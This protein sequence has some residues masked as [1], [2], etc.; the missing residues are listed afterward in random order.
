MD[1]IWVVVANQAGACIYSASRLGEVRSLID[2]FE[3][4]A[5][6]AHIQELVS[7]APGR[8]HDRQGEARH[9]METDVGMQEESIRRFARKIV[10]YLEKAAEQRKYSH[11]VIIAAPAFLGIVRKTVQPHLADRI[12]LEIPKDIVG[13]PVD[14]LQTLL[15]R[16]L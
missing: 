7:D 15:D 4:E 3:H 16:E 9:S 12:A 11:L 2:E 5:G 1:A 14:Q 13:S 8:V 10:A 6:R